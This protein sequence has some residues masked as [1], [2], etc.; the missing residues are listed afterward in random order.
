MLA[1]LGDAA[2]PQPLAHRQGHGVR[3]AERAG[4]VRRAGGCAAAP[5]RGRAALA[6]PGTGAG[7]RGLGQR[8]QRSPA[9]RQPGCAARLWPGPGRLPGRADAVAAAGAPGRPGRDLQASHRGPGG[10]PAARCRVPHPAARR[11]AALAARPCR[12]GHQPCWPRGRPG[13][14]CRGHHRTSPGAGGPARA[15]H[16]AREHR[17]V[18]DGSHH[19]GG[20]GAGRGAVQPHGRHDLRLAAGRCDR[21]AAGPVDPGTAARNPPGARGAVR[22]RRPH[23]PAHGP[24]GR[25]D[26]PARQR[27]GVSDRSVDLA[28][29]RRRPAAVDG[30]AEGRDRTAA[31]PSRR[32]RRN[33]SPKRPTARSRPSWPT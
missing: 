3:A 33:R 2:R 10:G 12:A 21:P 25:A 24:P 18:G 22:T 8:R 9:V 11:F 26:R 17:G 15:A 29:R 27:R 13:R 19:H 23:R 32:N 14:H 4:A 1:W 7:R 28:I 20:P 5:G 31:V 16:A 6:A 30:G